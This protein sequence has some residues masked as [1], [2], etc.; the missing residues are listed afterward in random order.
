[1]KNI[2]KMMGVALLACSMIMVSCKKDDENTSEGGGQG[3]GTTSGVAVT[4]DGAAQN[5]G[6]INTETDTETLQGASVYM[7]ET[8]KGLSNDEYVFPAFITYFINGSSFGHATEFRI[9]YNGQAYSGNAFFPT[10]AYINGGVEVED[11]IYGDWGL[12][13]CTVNSEAF[14][15]TAM[16]INADINCVMYDFEDYYDQYMAIM[17]AYQGGEM[18]QE[19]AAAALEAIQVDTKNMQMVIT[20]F[21]VN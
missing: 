12:D 11:D 6:F 7:I 14:D 15:A 3:G 5:L 21:K 18:S 10:E 17:L 2:F 8:A 9:N 4:W 1:M 19:D 13:D 16:T 20:N